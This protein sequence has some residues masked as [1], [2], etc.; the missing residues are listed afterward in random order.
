MTWF[1]RGG[2]EVAIRVELVLKVR[3]TYYPNLTFEE[4]KA[5]PDPS[6]EREWKHQCSRRWSRFETSAIFLR[7]KNFPLKVSF[8]EVDHVKLYSA[9]LYKNH[10]VSINQMTGICDSCVSWAWWNNSNR[11][12][13]DDDMLFD[14]GHSFDCDSI[15]GRW[16][17]CSPRKNDR[18]RE[19]DWWRRWKL[20]EVVDWDGD[21][22]VES[23]GHYLQF[24]K[25]HS[26][27]RCV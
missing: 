13:R 9:C 4:H 8:R 25:S 21:H 22:Q 23:S 12:I 16:W 10:A 17:T 27:S 1:D 24:A 6:T 26:L 11:T 18:E 19:W 7:S 2:G 15:I 20:F 3:K 5:P 14:Q